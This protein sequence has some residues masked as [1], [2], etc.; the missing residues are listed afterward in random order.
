IAA[1]MVL[2]AINAMTMTPARAT[3][4]FKNRKPGAHD[5]SHEAL[6]P[7]GIAILAGLLLCWLLDARAAAWAGAGE[8]SGWLWVVRAGLFLAGAMG[9]CFAAA[10]G[11]GLLGRLFRGFNRLFDWTTEVYGRLI[12]RALRLS[13]I[14]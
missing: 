9:A 4:V 2:S 10:M 3:A 7:W 14:V 13:A 1:A 12:G 11:N 6:P 8:S 5:Q